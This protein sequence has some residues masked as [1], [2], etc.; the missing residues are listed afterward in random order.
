ME[1]GKETMVFAEDQRWQGFRGG[2][3]TV[4]REMVATSRLDQTRKTQD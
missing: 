4:C 3:A 1:Y 2:Q